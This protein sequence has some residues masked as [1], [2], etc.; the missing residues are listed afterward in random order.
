MYKSFF[1]CQ[2]FLNPSDLLAFKVFTANASPHIQ[3]CLQLSDL[4]E[5]LKQ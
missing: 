1:F 2:D 5:K 3:G 4:R